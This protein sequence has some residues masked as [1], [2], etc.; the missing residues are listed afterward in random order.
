MPFPRSQVDLCIVFPD[1]ENP[2]TERQIDCLLDTWKMKSWIK[3]DLKQCDIGLLEGTFQQIRIERPNQIRLYGN[4]Q[5]GYRVFC[6]RS[7]QPI[8]AAF[9]AAVTQWRKGAERKMLCPACQEEHRLEMVITRPQAHFSQG[10]IIIRDVSSVQ[11]S[12]EA[13][14][15]IKNYLGEVDFVYKRIG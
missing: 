10:A 13:K 11:L 4:H 7:Q 15:D 8:A 6:P 12:N 5:G 2:K 9:S 1:L 14:D 3:D